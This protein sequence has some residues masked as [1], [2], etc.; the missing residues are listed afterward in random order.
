M[1]KFFKKLN[2]TALLQF[3]ANTLLEIAEI[4][5]SNQEIYSCSGKLFFMRLNQSNLTLKVLTK[6]YL[7]SHT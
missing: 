2:L 4:D 5:E 3:M 1:K 6:S 7:S